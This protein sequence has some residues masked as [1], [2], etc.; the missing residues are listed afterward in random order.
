MEK[1]N[2]LGIDSKFIGYRKLRD[3]SKSEITGDDFFKAFYAVPLFYNLHDYWNLIFLEFT[4][5]KKG[6]K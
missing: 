4:K 1:N 5:L 3:T 2:V 6:I